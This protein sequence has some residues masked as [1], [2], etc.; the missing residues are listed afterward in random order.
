M[1]IIWRGGSLLLVGRRK[2]AA[3]SI[4]FRSSKT[5]WAGNQ[6]TAGMMI[7]FLLIMQEQQQ[8]WW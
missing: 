6:A 7:A 1:A 8:R 3:Q 4:S 2:K 5:R